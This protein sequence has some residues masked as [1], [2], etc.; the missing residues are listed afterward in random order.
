MIVPPVK[1]II[2]NAASSKDVRVSWKID[3]SRYQ[4]V[5]K[6]GHWCFDRFTLQ[7]EILSLFPFSFF[8]FSSLTFTTFRLVERY[9]RAV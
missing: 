7:P 6:H 8:F 1:G 2:I 9:R 5:I 3:A 4:N